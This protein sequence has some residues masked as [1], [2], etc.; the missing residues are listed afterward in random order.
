M[1]SLLVNQRVSRDSGQ[2]CGMNRFTAHI[3]APYE[4]IG[5]HDI[6]VDAR[7]EYICIGSRHGLLI[8]DIQA[9][10]QPVK[11]LSKG[12]SKAS[13]QTVVQWHTSISHETTLHQAR[14][15]TS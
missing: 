1:K 10:F 8:I 5:G 12:Q 11:R 13:S 3:D 7:G 14:I 2:I 6:S 9:P 4:N 15:K